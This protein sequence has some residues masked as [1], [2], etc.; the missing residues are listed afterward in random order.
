VRKEYIRNNL[1][2]MLPLAAAALWGMARLIRLIRVKAGLAK[3]RK[4]K[5]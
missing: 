4:G 3:A 2:W 5:A 1:I